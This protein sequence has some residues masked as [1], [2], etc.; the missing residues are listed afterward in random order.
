MKITFELLTTVW[1]DRMIIYPAYTVAIV[2]THDI[3]VS[4]AIDVGFTH[5]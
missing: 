3:V 5:T 2:P 4:S 1:T